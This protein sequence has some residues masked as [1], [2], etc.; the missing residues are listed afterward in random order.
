MF[1]LFS[2]RR[3]FLREA[4]EQCTVDWESQNLVGCIKC[5]TEED[6]VMSEGGDV[7][8]QGWNPLK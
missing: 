8:R 4:L 5:L 3:E 2:E 7:S 1:R 6:S